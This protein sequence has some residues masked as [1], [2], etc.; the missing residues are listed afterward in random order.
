L[1]VAFCLRFPSAL[2]ASDTLLFCRVSLSFAFFPFFPL[3]CFRVSHLLLL[4]FDI[5]DDESNNNRRC[6]HGSTLSSLLHFFYSPNFSFFCDSF[7]LLLSSLCL[8]SAVL[9]FV[10]LSG[11]IICRSRWCSSHS[12]ALEVLLPFLDLGGAPSIHQ[13]RQCSFH[14]L[15]LAALLPFLGAPHGTF[16]VSASPGCF[17]V[18]RCSVRTLPRSWCSSLVVPSA[19]VLRTKPL[20]SA[21]LLGGF[22]HE[23]F[24]W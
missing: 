16:G 22:S 1:I 6:K 19:S 3:Y 15:A 9:S 13:P 18:L 12:S 21:L 17:L 11:T 7:L 20:A 14:S 8:T 23:T 5:T 24:I 2:N 4:L 10:G